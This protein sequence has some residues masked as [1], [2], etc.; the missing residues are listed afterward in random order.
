[1]GYTMATAVCDN[2]GA[3]HRLSQRHRYYEPGTTVSLW[4]DCTNTGDY[5]GVKHT[6]IA[7]DAKLPK[8]PMVRAKCDGCGYVRKVGQQ[9]KTYSPGDNLIARCKNRDAGHQ[10]YYREHTIIDNGGVV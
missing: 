3:R 6:I 4:C 7:K 1:M 8:R 5:S 2:C 10:R 9:R